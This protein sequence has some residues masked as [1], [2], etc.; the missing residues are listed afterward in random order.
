[1]L[2]LL[3]GMPGRNMPFICEIFDLIKPFLDGYVVDN[4]LEVATVKDKESSGDRVKLREANICWLE[5]GH[6]RRPGKVQESNT[7]FFPPPNLGAL[8]NM[9]R[10]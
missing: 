7:S 9:P 1:M 2:R 5:V 4:G 8:S 3:A 6:S 10:Y